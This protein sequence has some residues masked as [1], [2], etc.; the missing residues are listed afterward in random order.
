[1]TNTYIYR[2]S[3]YSDAE[4]ECVEIAL[5]LPVGVAIRDSKYPTGPFIQLS[6]ASWEAFHRALTREEL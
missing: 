6:L 5:A 2:K 1:M 3:S 4:H